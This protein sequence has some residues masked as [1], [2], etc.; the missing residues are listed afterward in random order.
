VY[1]LLILVGESDLLS[2]QGYKGKSA[3]GANV[4]NLYASI[5]PPK[6]TWLIELGEK[7]QYGWWT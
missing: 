1:D 2:N 6:I 7:D 5:L 3:K 4:N